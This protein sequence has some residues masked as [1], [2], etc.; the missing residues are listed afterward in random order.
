MATARTTEERLRNWLDGNQAERERLCAAVLRLDSRFSR[1]ML[2]RPKGGRDH[3]RDLEAV[4]GNEQYAFGAVSFV[5]GANDSVDQKRRIKK[6]FRQDLEAAL[7]ARP[8]LK[9][10][11][12]FT[13]LDLTPAEVT[14]LRERAASMG[15]VVAEIIFRERMLMALQSPSGFAARYQ[16]LDIK[17]S[18]EE[19]VA[20][21][22]DYGEQLQS[23]IAR[24]FTDVDRSLER[25]EFFADKSSPLLWLQ[26][27]LTLDR[28]YDL[29]AI[30]PFRVLFQFC[31]RANVSGGPAFCIAAEDASVHTGDERAHGFRLYVGTEQRPM[32]DLKHPFSRNT[33]EQLF[34]GGELLRDPSIGTLG[35]L[36]RHEIGVFMSDHLAGRLRSIQILA[37]VYEVARLDRDDIFEESVEGPPWWPENPH[38]PELALTARDLTWVTLTRSTGL[39]FPEYLPNVPWLLDFYSATPRRSQ[40]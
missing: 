13:N 25:I 22:R 4:F 40:L 34:F 32:Y 5:N 39:P 16:H 27:V 18:E 6:K 8:D 31:K 2:R 10:F 15:G 35:A 11:V 21:F 33:A 28:Q 26:V 37:N 24:R 19:Q 17:M 12:F 1:I 38:W 7:K 29:S 3:G 30:E 14:E 23:V 9:V 20:F 36:E